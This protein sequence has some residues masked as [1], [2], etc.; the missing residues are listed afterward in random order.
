MVCVVATSKVWHP[1]LVDN[2][3]RLTSEKFLTITS[4]RELNNDF[5]LEVQPEYVF[6]PHWSHIIPSEIFDSFEC[7]I[8]HMTDLPFGRGGSPLQNLIANGIY[9]T[10]ISALRCEAGLDS[11]PIYLKKSLS[12]TGRAQDIYKK[13]SLIIEEMIVKILQ[14]RMVPIPQEGKIVTFSRRTPMQGNMETLDNLNSVYDYIRMLDAD[15][16]PN[17]F[18]E[19]EYLKFEFSYAMIQGDE[20][21]AQV[22]IKPKKE[23][24]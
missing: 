22:R 5:L 2:L 14:D 24:S 17:A 18:I 6:F 19:T 15:G 1:A 4:P 23:K 8:F 3:Q 10:K 21:L 16:Y 12:L 20:V 7:V 13:A 9:E 11:G